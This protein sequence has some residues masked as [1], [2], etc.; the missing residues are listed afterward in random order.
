M[1]SV[2][3]EILTIG[4]EILYGHI[5]DTNSQF[6][7]TALDKA[8]IQVIRKTSV[9]DNREAIINGLKSAEAVADIII[10]TGGLGPTKDDI[11]KKTLADY[12]Q[13][14]LV[15]NEAVL[16]HVENLFASRGRVMN[17][18]NKTQALIPANAQ[19]IHNAV[20][21]A[22]GMWI[23]HQ[24]KVFISMP[25]VPH[26]MK[27]MME[28][29]IVP[30]LRHHFQTPAIIHKWI[31]TINIPESTL[32]EKIEK[33]EDALPAHLKLAY[34]PKMGQVRLR[35]TGKGDDAGVLNA[36]LEA[37][38]AQLIPLIKDHIYGYED[39]EIE[40]VVGS[41]LREKNKT[42]STAESCTGGYLAHLLT[43]VAGSSHYFIGS[44]V[45][46]SNQI[47]MNELDVS[48]AILEAYGA[49]SEPTVIAMAEGIRKKF[50]TSIGLAT[51]GVAGP[52][53]GSP[54][55]PVGTIW[56]AYADERETFAKKLTLTQERMLNITLTTNFL[57]NFLRMKLSE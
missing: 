33:W 9:G 42:V 14:T 45:A 11:T 48:P 28:E 51:S 57:L 34:L 4:D 7:S 54:E 37:Q 43:S 39:D 41:L 52:D 36:E 22:P 32:A 21:T 31:K 5:T 19:V 8:G 29:L 35:L 16:S 49:V 13:T 10:I 15:M 2:Y 55:K 12:F 17:D 24:G 50:G 27:K 30:K 47:K 20:G 44:I 1:K 25:G 18:L 38:V 40:K 3:A 23:E 46:Y 53:G 26:E 6:I 56:V